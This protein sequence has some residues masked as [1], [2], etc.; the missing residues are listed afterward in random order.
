MPVSREAYNF[1]LLQA[2]YATLLLSSGT[3]IYTVSKMLT[4]KNVGTTQIYTKVMDSDKRKAA[5]RL[6]IKK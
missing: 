5:E 2:T 6:R 3:D 4:H 1:P